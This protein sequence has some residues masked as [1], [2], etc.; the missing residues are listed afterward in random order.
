[1]ATFALKLSHNEQHAIIVCFVGK[2]TSNP[3][4]IYSACIQCM[5]TSVLQSQQ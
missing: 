2:K 5:M 3:N 4:Q 1:M